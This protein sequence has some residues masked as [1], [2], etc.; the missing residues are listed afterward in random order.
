MKQRTFTLSSEMESLLI[1]SSIDNNTSIDKMFLRALGLLRISEEQKKE[2][3][4]LGIIQE[5]KDGTLR[6]VAKI[7]GL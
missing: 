7:Q 3:N 5:D 4:T 6:V 1:R 2:G